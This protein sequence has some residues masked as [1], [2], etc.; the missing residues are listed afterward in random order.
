MTLAP[1]LQKSIRYG[2]A[3]VIV[4]LLAFA[5][6]TY[7]ELSA[8]RKYPVALPT[9]D[10]ELTGD[11]RAPIVKTHGTWTSA[12]GIPGTLGTSSIECDKATMRC[13]ESTAQVIFISGRGLLESKMAQFEIGSWSD[14]EIVAKPEVLRCTTRT[15]VLDLV[16]KRARSGST[17]NPDVNNCEPSAPRTYELVAGYTARAQ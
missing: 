16:K 14:R 13:A 4:L 5:L 9:Y 12:G 15:L 2:E 17:P 7:R 11:P 1:N 3:A 10:F 6:L 8:L